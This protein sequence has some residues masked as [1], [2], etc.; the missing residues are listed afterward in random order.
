MKVST[1]T[2]SRPFSPPPEASD[3]ASIFP[4]PSRA[5]T[6]LATIPSTP[7]DTPDKLVNTTIPAAQTPQV[8]VRTTSTS[9]T[10]SFCLPTSLSFFHRLT[11]EQTPWIEHT[12]NSRPITPISTHDARTIA[13]QLSHASN[14]PISALSIEKALFF[15][16]SY[17]LATSAA[18][19]Q[20]SS[21]IGTFP[22]LFIVFPHL[23]H[24]TQHPALNAN[25]LRVWHDQIV[26]PAFD[27]AW[28][29]SH[30]APTY[31]A[32]IDG[33]T[34]I[35]QPHGVRTAFDARPWSGLAALLQKRG[36]CVK[37]VREVWPQDSELLGQAWTSMTGM[38]QGFPGL[39]EYRD[40]VLLAVGRGRGDRGHDVG[41][42]EV[43]EKVQGVWSEFGHVHEVVRDSFRVVVETVVGTGKTKDAGDDVGY[44]DE[45]GRT[46]SCDFEDQD[47]NED[48][49][50]DEDHGEEM[51]KTD[52]RG[53]KRKEGS[54]VQPED[55]GDSRGQRS[56]R[57][58]M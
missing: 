39:K 53:G 20:L 35:Q 38:L 16:S 24:T 51:E 9:T 54:R 5:N 31:G 48:E 23:S 44:D 19:A 28:H 45:V 30:Q 43:F 41:G 8:P 26:K 46:F 17:P 58:K 13:A 32:A 42:S 57:R 34:R 49:D 22:L 1:T 36:E 47:E 18:D 6:S 3:P 40:P 37:A 2:T 12:L 21:K 15:G 10:L 14:T 4:A 27:A 55:D 33:L 52:G 25:F 29:A 11:W 7:P 56:K 50:E